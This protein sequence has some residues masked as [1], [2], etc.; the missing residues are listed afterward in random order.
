MPRRPKH[1]FDSK[2]G[3]D[4]VVALRQARSEMRDFLEEAKDEKP[5]DPSRAMTACASAAAQAIRAADL[6]ID[7]LTLR[8]VGG[9]GSPLSIF[10]QVQSANPNFMDQI[11]SLA[12]T[13]ARMSVDVSGADVVGAVLKQTSMPADDGRPGRRVSLATG[14]DRDNWM[15]D[16]FPFPITTNQAKVTHMQETV[17][18][19]ASDA[20]LPSEKTE[21]AASPEANVSYADVEVALR[22]IRATLPVTEEALADQQGARSLLEGRLMALANRRFEGQ[23]LLGN[24][25]A[26]NIQ[27]LSTLTGIQTEAVTGAGAGKRIPDPAASA[28]SLI[29]KIMRNGEEMPDRIIMA[30]EVFA[31]IFGGKSTE[32]GHY[33]ASGAPGSVGAE[34][35]DIP[36][37]VSPWLAAGAKSG[38][39]TMV[40]GNF[41]NHADLLVRQQA[42]V[43]A[44]YSGTDFANYI[45]RLRVVLRAAVAWYR[46]AAFGTLTRG[47]D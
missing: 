13:K 43:V 47:A 41:R 12:E 33:T 28:L 3:D 4:A 26:P 36:V 18:P 21:G 20:N 24:G 46:P 1:P 15:L 7:G 22:T 42:Q 11:G 29:T 16:A 35:W 32:D 40:M 44:G 30:P 39:V 5:M 23:A 34:L 19:G 45:L 8:R 17:T 14:Y 27:G 2:D 31:D 38:D 37:S 25:T 10:D 9:A 6:A